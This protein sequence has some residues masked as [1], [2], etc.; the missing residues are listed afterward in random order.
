M[1]QR[2]LTTSGVHGVGP[3]QTARAATPQ[4]SDSIDVVEMFFML[5]SNWKVLFLSALIGAVVMGGYHTFMVKP[6][7]RAYTEMY[8]TSSDS[9]ISLSDLQLGSAL[10]EDYQ[11]II[12]SRTVLNQVIDDMQLNTDYRGLREMVTVSNSSGT[13]IIRTTVTTLDLALSRDIANDLLL[14]SIERIYQIVGTSEP[15]VIDYA[16]A[17]A[18]EDVTPVILS[19]MV[20]GSFVCVLLVAALLVIR[21]VMDSTIKTDDDVEKYLQLPVLS[22]VPF[23]K[24]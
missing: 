23:Y 7:Y 20:V 17:E 19:Y 9:V 4:V 1:E 8:I 15:M 5:L 21:S 24:E 12:T 3:S 13:H 6:Q 14:V 22:A 16:E 2:A 11:A 10:T 18:V